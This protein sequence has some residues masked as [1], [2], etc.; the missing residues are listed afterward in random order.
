MFCNWRQTQH[1]SIGIN[2]KAGH[3]GL[4]PLS[5][6]IILITKCPRGLACNGA[7]IAEAHFYDKRANIKITLG[8][9]CCGKLPLGKCIRCFP[10][11]FDKCVT[12][13]KILECNSNEAISR[14]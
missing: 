4:S 2:K 10:A 12:L 3:T 13:G 6:P 11:N 8:N 14:K 5:L 7:D 9:W 1:S